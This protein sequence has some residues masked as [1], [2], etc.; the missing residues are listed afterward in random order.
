MLK[1]R[2]SPMLKSDK[3]LQRSRDTGSSEKKGLLVSGGKLRGES[4]SEEL[5]ESVLEQLPP[6]E[7]GMSSEVRLWM[8][9]SPH[10]SSSRYFCWILH[11]LKQ[12]F[13]YFLSHRLKRIS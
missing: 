13:L 12:K 6:A 4:I 5:F 9:P 1:S 2:L 3:P 8:G 11:P 7:M 10:I